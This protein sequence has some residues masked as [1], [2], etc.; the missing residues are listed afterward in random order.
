M[1]L[2]AYLLPIIVAFFL[3]A[4]TMIFKDNE[5]YAMGLIYVAASL[6]I[7][8]L[9]YFLVI[10]YILEPIRVYLSSRG[11]KIHFKGQDS[12]KYAQETYILARDGGGQLIASHIF[13]LRVKAEEDF[14]YNTLITKENGKKLIYKRVLI[15]SNKK[16]EHE[17]V[18]QMFELKTLGIDVRLYLWKKID[19]IFNKSLIGILPRFN[20]LLYKSPN[21]KIVRVLIGFEKVRSRSNFF[22][23]RLNVAFSFSNNYVYSALFNYFDNIAVHPDVY[24]VD[25]YEVYKENI[26]LFPYSESEQFIIKELTDFAYTNND[27]VHLGA[28]GK[29][30]S[31]LKNMTRFNNRANHVSDID[32]LFIVR[33]NKNR[34]K[35]DI[36]DLLINENIEIIWGDD[37]S[38]FYN[39]RPDNK[40]LVDIEIFELN[41]NF[42]K[43]HSLLG[44]SIFSNY[45]NIFTE[46]SKTVD[47]CIFIPKNP[48]SKKER[49][50]RFLDNR[51]SITEFINVL[52]NTNEKQ[53]DLRRSLSIN[54]KNLCWVLTGY[55]SHDVEIDLSFLVNQK[56]LSSDDYSLIIQILDIDSEDLKLNYF[57]YKEKTLELLTKFQNIALELNK[58]I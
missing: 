7:F 51:K 10:N 41:S 57:T 28:F 3:A 37:E 20:F 23:K 1:K 53:V 25:S 50:K 4:Y 27:V 52:S 26:N 30:A 17:W 42:Y 34:I 39:I 9:L 48:I 6:A 21:G 16:E 58:T 11:M 36:I 8:P 5:D 29:T 15:F 35:K 54:I 22:T 55:R 32:L 49:S 33:E 47:D 18:K 38:Y 2:L 19:L 43:A 31:L 56:I 12:F 40:I 24:E 14:A 13:Q 46:N 44:Y 45:L